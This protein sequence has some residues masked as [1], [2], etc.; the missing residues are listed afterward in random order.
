MV[1]FHDPGLKDFIYHD[2]MY[3]VVS[4]SETNIMQ[5]FCLSCLN[6]ISTGLF[7]QLQN[8]LQ[9]CQWTVVGLRLL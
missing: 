9:E 7:G 5:L 8:T 1:A 6:R 4:L 3:G 2:V